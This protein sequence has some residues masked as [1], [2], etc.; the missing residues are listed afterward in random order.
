MKRCNALATFFMCITLVFANGAYANQRD[1]INAY[2]HE[3]I[4][5]PW[6][7]SSNGD[8]AYILNS[9]IVFTH[10]LRTIWGNMSNSS[11]QVV[12][13]NFIL[14]T[15]TAINQ[16]TWYGFYGTDLDPAITSLSFDIHF[17]DDNAGLP[18]SELYSQTFLASIQDSG[19]Q[20]MNSDNTY[21]NGRIIYQFRANLSPTFSATAGKKFWIEIAE[22]DSLTPA[23]GDTQWIWSKSIFN[24]APTTSAIPDTGQTQCYNNTTEIPCPQEGNPFYGQDAQ[25]TNRSPSFTKIDDQGN[26]LP[27]S[28][29]TWQI[30]RD[31]VTRLMWE[32][33]TDDGSIHDKDNTYNWQASKDAITTQ[34]NNTNFGGYSD[35][36]LPTK[37]E[38]HSIVNHG[39]YNPSTYTFYFPNTIPLNGRYWTSTLY[40]PNTSLVWIV[41]FYKGNDFDGADKLA[42]LYFRA[43]RGEE[44]TNIFIDNG[45]GTISDTSTDLLWQKDT[46]EVINWE[47]ALAYCSNLNLA[48][49]TDW[50]LPNRLELLSIV[51][52]NRYNPAIDINYFPDTNSQYS[53]LSST[54]TV[55]SLNRAWGVHFWHGSSYLGNLKIPPDTRY[56]RAVRSGIEK[57]RIFGLFFGNKQTDGDDIYRGDLSAR[58]VQRV[59]NNLPNVAYSHSFVG[60]EETGGIPK[61]YIENSIEMVGRLMQPGDTLFLY[62]TGHGRSGIDPFQETT[63]MPGD[64]MI[65][66]GKYLWDISGNH[67]LTDDELYSFL[68]GLNHVNKWV[69]ID[70]CHSGGFWGNQNPEDEGDLEKLENISFVA[71]SVENEKSEGITYVEGSNE[72]VSIFADALHTGFS[73]DDQGQNL[74]L[75]INPRDGFISFE[76]VADWIEYWTDLKNYSGQIVIEMD[77][78]DKTTFAPELWNPVFESSV[79]FTNVINS[80]PKESLLKAHANG[81]Y[82]GIVDI[83]ITFDASGSYD[84]NDTLVSYEWDWN[85]D[86]IFDEINVD[87]TT[88][89]IWHAAYSGLVTLKITDNDGYI[90]IDHTS[91][92][93]VEVLPCECDF[94]S[95]DGDVD[96]TDLASYIADPAGFSVA[97]FAADFG[98]IDCP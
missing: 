14:L 19:F 33:K 3:G 6:S 24:P 89:H 70:A 16:V 49:Y 80:E 87:P 62:I 37:T 93:V 7:L 79:N 39:L 64:E 27:D 48:G 65:Q 30:V 41:G 86:G 76:E 69:L 5:G 4:N 34:L 36:R 2:R 60:D 74:Q 18:G 20:V 91:V 66:T 71:S 22:N 32:I 96:G 31:N 94:E 54:T 72:F 38:L 25:F 78:G 68:I 57:P 47:T 1:N 42:T 83:P 59:F 58:E 90:Q 45:D 85:G 92:D 50:R 88:E 35:W 73:F 10:P 81:P 46:I 67:V 63:L 26:E 11:G 13:D 61:N 15:N 97:D 44:F 43:V 29:E 17:F 9:S 40:R 23:V 8:Q 82:E 51:D 55:T 52:Y 77:F 28:A 98:R 95:A 84:P 53:Y 56:I 21:Y 75:D 12:A